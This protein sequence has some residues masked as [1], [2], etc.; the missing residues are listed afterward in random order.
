MKRIIKIEA[1][2]EATKTRVRVHVVIESSWLTR[3]SMT[4]LHR[5]L[6]DRLSLTLRANPSFNPW[7]SDM[8]VR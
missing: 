5:N 1:K 2:D 7:L 3:D 8:K 4:L 6:A